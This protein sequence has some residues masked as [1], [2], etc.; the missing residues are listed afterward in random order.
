MGDLIFV[1]S[2]PL[3]DQ[4][5]EENKWKCYALLADEHYNMCLGVYLHRVALDNWVSNKIQVCGGDFFLN[6]TTWLYMKC[7]EVCKHWLC[8]FYCTGILLYLHWL[9][10]HGAASLWV[11]LFIRNTNMHVH[12]QIFIPAHIYGKRKMQS[13][14]TL[15]FTTSKLWAKWKLYHTLPISVRHSAFMQCGKR[16]NKFLC[17]SGRERSVGDGMAVPERRTRFYKNWWEKEL[18]YSMYKNTYSQST[19]M[20]CITDIV[21]LVSTQKLT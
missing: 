2:G 21:H 17:G 5:T 7:M 6:M 8:F 11:C 19:Q 4:V 1:P 20:L 18:K 16:I 10:G 14:N 3:N 12:W 9:Y 13:F 15:G